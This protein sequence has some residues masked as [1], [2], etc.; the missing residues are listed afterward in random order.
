[1]ELTTAQV[2]YK[3]I[4][5]E[6][7]VKLGVNLEKVIKFSKG[8]RGRNYSESPAELSFSKNVKKECGRRFYCATG[9]SKIKFWYYL[10][11]L[12][13]FSQKIDHVILSEI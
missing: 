8:G 6:M 7:P 4:V 5:K 1:M 3:V 9:E 10:R 11:L 2:R 12:L 13:N